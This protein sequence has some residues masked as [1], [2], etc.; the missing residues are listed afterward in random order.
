MEN[1]TV[2]YNDGSRIVF[3]RICKNCSKFNKRMCTLKSSDPFYVCDKHCLSVNAIFKQ[4][5]AVPLYPIPV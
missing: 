4:S 5:K 1:V 2:T 3:C